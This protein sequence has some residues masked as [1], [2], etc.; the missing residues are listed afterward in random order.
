[1]VQWH[2]AV[3]FPVSPRDDHISDAKTAVQY[4]CWHLV[5]TDA[6]MAAQFYSDYSAAEL[7]R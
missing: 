5:A 1:M 6:G 3:R 4:C 2:D 7:G